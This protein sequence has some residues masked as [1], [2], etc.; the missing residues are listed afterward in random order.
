[1]TYA[2]QVSVK[3]YLRLAR[4]FLSQNQS[5]DLLQKS[6]ALNYNKCNVTKEIWIMLP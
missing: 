4:K 2:L 6:S 5:F 3:K 1:M